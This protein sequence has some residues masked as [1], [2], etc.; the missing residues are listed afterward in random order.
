MGTEIDWAERGKRM[1]RTKMVGRSVSYD[2]YAEPLAVLGAHDTPAILRSEMRRG[3]FTEGF[4]ILC[5]GALGTDMVR[6][7]G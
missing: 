4:M 7:N 3:P 5:L 1:S 6:L 2:G